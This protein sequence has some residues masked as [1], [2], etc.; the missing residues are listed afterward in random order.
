MAIR[1]INKKE[2][3][4]HLVN[5]KIF[6]VLL[7]EQAIMDIRFNWLKILAK[8]GIGE[9]IIGNFIVQAKDLI[10]IGTSNLKEDV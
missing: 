8:G 7:S 10:L 2:Y 6:T 3:V 4:F 1:A 5:G 9:I